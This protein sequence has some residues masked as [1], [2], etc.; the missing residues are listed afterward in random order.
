MVGRSAR[1]VCSLCSYSLQF[2]VGSIYGGTCH[3][4]ELRES[5]DWFVRWWRV[6]CFVLLW[7]DS[8]DRFSFNASS[9][10]SCQ[11]QSTFAIPHDRRS[12]REF[13]IRT[14]PIPN[15]RL[16][17]RNNSRNCFYNWLE[18]CG[19]NAFTL[20]AKNLIQCKCY[21]SL[22]LASRERA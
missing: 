5:C 21:V 17:R 8:L 7:S 4:A 2:L 13:G 9:I 6:D 16:H 15:S 19:C 10:P 22:V 11:S 3:R 14:Y 20:F 12:K 18:S 1:W